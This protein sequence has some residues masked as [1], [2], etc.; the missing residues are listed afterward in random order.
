MV[1][2]SVRGTTRVCLKYQNNTSDRVSASSP[3]AKTAAG[4]GLR[5]QDKISAVASNSSPIVRMAAGLLSLTWLI[6]Y[7]ALEAR[8]AGE[9]EPAVSEGSFRWTPVSA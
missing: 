3:V 1:S 6:R 5:Y 7:S 4:G 8:A 9:I 2:L